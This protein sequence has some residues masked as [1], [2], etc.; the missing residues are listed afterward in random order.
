MRVILAGGGTGGHVIP[1]IA[2]AQQLQKE[3]GAEVVFIGT[4]R[5]IENRLVPPAGFELRLVEVGA[6]NRVSL[7]T[8]IEDPVRLASRHLERRSNSRTFG[9][10]L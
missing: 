2:I 8:R 1:A 9:L 4:S 7:G 5:G 3:Y 6:L 10:T